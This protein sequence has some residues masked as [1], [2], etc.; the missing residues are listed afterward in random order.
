[1]SFR[2]PGEGSILKRGWANGVTRVQRSHI[3]LR[4]ESLAKQYPAGR[5]CKHCPTKLRRTNPS[6]VCEY[7]HLQE[8]RQSAIIQLAV[9][10]A[11]E[12]KRGEVMRRF[13]QTPNDLL[14]Q[15]RMVS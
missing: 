1:M 14:A 13:M 6:K 4:N 8:Q 9:Q 3:D 10:M 7:C 12:G 11:K 15:G 5:I 2:L